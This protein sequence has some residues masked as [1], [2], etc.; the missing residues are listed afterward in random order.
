MA[1]G[2]MSES[3]AIDCEGVQLRWYDHWLKGIDNDVRQDTPVRLFIMGANVWRDEQE[4]PLACAQYTRY[5]LH[6]RGKANSLHGDGVLRPVTPGLEPPHHFLYDPRHP[7]PPRGGTLCQRAEPKPPCIVLACADR[8]RATRRVQR[9]R[10]Q[11]TKSWGTCQRHAK[12][13]EVVDDARVA[14][15]TRGTAHALTNDPEGAA[16]PGAGRLFRGLQHFTLPRCSPHRLG[17]E[18]PLHTARGLFPFSFTWQDDLP[19]L[20]T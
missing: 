3:F 1:F 19:V 6:S 10:D 14:P 16:P 8:D 11:N 12:A 2:V 20:C 4:W 9:D 15:A 7:V 5:Y 17:I 13:N 18:A